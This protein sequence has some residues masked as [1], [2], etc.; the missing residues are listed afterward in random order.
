[1]LL[2]HGADEWLRGGKCYA[3]IRAASY[4]TNTAIIQ[5]LIDYGADINLQDDR[6][7]SALYTASEHGNVEAAQLLID[8]GAN[9][10]MKG[11]KYGNAIGAA[12]TGRNPQ[13]RVD[14]LETLLSNVGLPAQRSSPGNTPLAIAAWY[15]NSEAMKIFLRNGSDPNAVDDFGRTAL[16]YASVH[17]SVKGGVELLLAR[18]AVLDV[19]DCYGNTPLIM[20]VRNGVTDAVYPLARSGRVDLH[21][22]DRMGRSAMWWA[23]HTNAIYMEL[24]R[25]LGVDDCELTVEADE[26]LN[27]HLSGTGDLLCDDCFGFFSQRDSHVWCSICCNGVA[28]CSTC[29]SEGVHCLDTSH[30]LAVCDTNECINERRHDT[31]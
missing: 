26:A 3:L 4:W 29:N 10:I 1:M 9:V 12:A 24:L 17:L 23:K 14:I 21:A 16:F 18:G 30:R 7:E 6:G 8:S 28:I 19:K 5:L 20:A 2:E 13:S 25:E 27:R 31:V 11:G 22:T 15:G